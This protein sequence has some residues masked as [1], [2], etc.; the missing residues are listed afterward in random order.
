MGKTHDRTYRSGGKNPRFSRGTIPRH[1][2][3]CLTNRGMKP[4]AQPILRPLPLAPTLDWRTRGRKRRRRQGVYPHRTAWVYCRP[5]LAANSGRCQPARPSNA[6]VVRKD[7]IALTSGAAGV[8]MSRLRSQGHK[9]KL[10][11]G[12][13]EGVGKRRGAKGQRQ[14]RGELRRHRRRQQGKPYGK[15]TQTRTR[16]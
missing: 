8:S 11:S 1:P 16:Q 7:A 14:R 4:M 3:I 5:A 6:P 12:G 10:W 13:R 15:Q 2:P 9:T